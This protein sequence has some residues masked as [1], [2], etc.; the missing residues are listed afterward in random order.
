MGLCMQTRHDLVL[1][2]EWGSKKTVIENDKKSSAQ[3]R[4]ML[5]VLGGGGHV[6]WAKKAD[7]RVLKPDTTLPVFDMRT[8]PMLKGRFSKGITKQ[9]HYA[10]V[11]K[12]YVSRFSKFP[13]TPAALLTI[14]Q[15]C[16]LCTETLLYRCM[17]A[18]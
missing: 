1:D 6:V 8:V 18:S 12:L 4:V 16:F 11:L 3:R 7:G 9:I 5:T 13:L 15:N 2:C 10:R 14:S 17:L